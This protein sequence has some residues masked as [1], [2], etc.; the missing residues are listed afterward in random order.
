MTKDTNYELPLSVST[1]RST[2]LQ[3]NYSVV[4][5]LL[6]LLP[7]LISPRKIDLQQA[8]MAQDML[9]RA[10]Y[11]IADIMLQASSLVSSFVK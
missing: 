10:G 5:E 4:L 3:L 11:N 2:Q 7:A 6:A 8:Q 9:F 1:Y